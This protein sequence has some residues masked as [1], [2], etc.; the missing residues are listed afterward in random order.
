LTSNTKGG[1]EAKGGG[2]VE[3][4]VCQQKKKKDPPGKGGANGGGG[5]GTPKIGRGETRKHNFLYYKGGKNPFSGGKKIKG[6]LQ[7]KRFCCLIFGKKRRKERE[8]GG[9]FIS[10]RVFYGMLCAT[11][12]TK[13]KKEE[14]RKMMGAVFYFSERFTSYAELNGE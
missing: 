3:F 7:P 8:K 12:S 11:S 6:A 14:G 1:G 2:H 13:G 10:P 9:S 5:K 4:A